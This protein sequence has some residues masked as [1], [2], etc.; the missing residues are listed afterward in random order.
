MSDG[1]LVVDDATG[2]VV[3][4][5]A[6]TKNGRQRERVEMGLIH[7]TDIE[8][9]TVWDSREEGAPVAEPQHPAGADRDEVA[10]IRAFIASVPDAAGGRV[11]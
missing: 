10:T 6:C 3:H 7:R 1:F 11:P 5:V 2:E 9:F 8:R 4:F